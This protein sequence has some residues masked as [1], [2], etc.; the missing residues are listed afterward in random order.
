MLIGA[1]NDV[2]MLSLYTINEA[3]QSLRAMYCTLNITLWRLNMYASITD[4]KHVHNASVKSDKMLY[5]TFKGNMLI[6]TFN[7]KYPN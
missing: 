1:F 6:G 2:F 3:Y 4:A 7:D 5:L